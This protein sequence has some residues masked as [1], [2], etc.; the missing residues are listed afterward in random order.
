MKLPP[1]AIKTLR[2]LAALA[3][4]AGGVWLLRFAAQALFHC[5]QRF[6]FC[7]AGC[8]NKMPRLPVFGGRGKCAC[9]NNFFNYMA[10]YRRVFKFAYAA[11]CSDC[12]KHILPPSVFPTDFQ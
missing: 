4:A 10:R 6:F 2:L 8:Y 9:F 11:P 3:L 5:G 7:F 12:V 1:T